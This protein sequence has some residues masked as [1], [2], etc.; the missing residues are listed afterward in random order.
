MTRILLVR[1]GQTEFN[2]RGIYQGQMD[3]PLTQEG[4]DQARA[5]APRIRTMDSCPTMYSSDLGR[6]RHTAQLIADPHHHV[7]AEDPGLR[8]RDF[9]IFQGL[10]KSDVQTLHPAAWA[11]HQ[12]GD[13]DYVIPGGESQQQLLERVVGT[14]GRIAARHAEG[15][16]VAVTHGGTLGAFVKY[17]LGLPVDARRRFD[18]GNTSISLF[19]LD[20]DGRWMVR[21]FGD[22]AHL[23]D[24]PTPNQT[25]G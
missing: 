2:T 18:M 16:V 8:E 23:P 21:F 24:L 25:E 20:G 7:L 13:P 3:S 22:L 19:Y 4:I 11:R 10:R 9:G 1:H 17:V 15:L 6:A 14:T 5:L 12:S